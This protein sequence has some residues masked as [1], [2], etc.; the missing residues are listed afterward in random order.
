MEAV[1]LDL[2]GTLLSNNRLILDRTRDVLYKL[3]EKGVKIIIATGRTYTS[4]K[5]YKDMLGLDT[6][7][8]CFNG[9][10]LVDGIN[11][12]TILEIPIK[13]EIALKC[14][15]L[16]K[17]LGI[18]TN[19]YQNEVWY[20]EEENE[21]TKIY[22]ETSG[23]PY[24]IKK[25]IEFDNLDMTKLLFIGENEKLLELDK[26]F[27]EQLESHINRAFSKKYFLEVMNKSVNKGETLLKLFEMEGI[28]KTKVIAFGDG[29]NDLEM[30]QIVGE[31]V[32]MGNGSEELKKLIG[33]VCDTNDNDGI[34]KYLEQYL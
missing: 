12:E 27:G 29:M 9:A 34:A 25:I 5:P 20:I 1:V 14:I 2:D 30:L 32:V 22:Q 16:A 26:K 6:P 31:G 19:Y 4:L 3:R 15:N 24:E 18:H 33:R 8:V 13:G 28:D 11:E 17:E 23:L 10:K 7:V 21:E